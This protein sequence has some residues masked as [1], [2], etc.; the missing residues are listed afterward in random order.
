LK[1]LHIILAPLL[2]VF[3]SGCNN[4][5]NAPGKSDQGPSRYLTIKGSD[6]M[7]HLVSTWA[8]EFMNM[9]PGTELS[10]TGGG[11]GTGIAALIN[12]TTDICAASREIKKNEIGLAESNGVKPIEIAV[13]R[14]A[15]VVVV[16]PDNPIE[17]LTMGQL[18]AIFTG[19]YKSWSK[20]RGPDRPI[21]V[22]S[23]ESS[24]GTF[25]FFQEK[26]LK[27]KDYAYRAR[28]MPGTSAVIQ[29][30]SA[31]EWSVGYVGLGYALEVGDEVKMIQVKADADSP[32]ITPS[33]ETVKNG[34]Y[35]ISRPLLLYIN[36]QAQGLVKDFIDFC[37]SKKGQ[38][39]VREAGY[40]QVAE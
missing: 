30:V 24:S 27:K 29:S 12:K 14:D 33:E 21:L 38:Q 34:E 26:V 19:E 4:A 25:Q 23:R 2:F 9:Y 22:L 10:V 16:H 31:D 36:S 32:P 39:T 20:V 37:L 6:T 40:V 28:L 18:G 35:P 15:I 11:S 1:I 17:A 13:A 8:E 3:L 5:G 7:V